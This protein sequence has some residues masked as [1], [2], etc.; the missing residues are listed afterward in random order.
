MHNREL[1]RPIKRL[2]MLALAVAFALVVAY[3]E[4]VLPS[5]V[6]VAPGVKIGLSNIAPLIVL[7]LA[8]A[9]DA[10]IVMIIKCLLNAV[11]VGGL[12]GLMYSL[13]AGILALAV[14]VLLFK[15]L[16]GKMSI[17]MISLI[18]AIVF[19]AVQL[20]MASVITGVNLIALLPYMCLASVLV[21]A[22]TGL[23][24]YYII[25]K[26]PYSVFR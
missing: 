26:L 1:N 19:N 22:F 15:L 16:F 10:F 17:A 3:V 2:A 14:E 24:T 13:P 25:K 20:F 21:G 12:S 23:L 7:V 5:P 9:G 6:P 4:S 18:G 11:I 8:S